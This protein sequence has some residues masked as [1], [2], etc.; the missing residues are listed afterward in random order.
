MRVNVY[1]DGFNFYYG[2][3][4]RHRDCKWLNLRA[5]F[6]SILPREDIAQIRYFTALIEQRDDDPQKRQRQLTLIRA[7]QT[8]PGIS[9]HYGTFLTN[10]K[11]LPLVTPCPIA[12]KARLCPNGPRSAEVQRTEEKGSDVNLATYLLVDGFQNAY[13][14]AVVVSNDSDLTEPIKLVHSVLKKKVGILNPHASP[15]MQLRQASSWFHL[16]IHRKALLASQFPVEF[17]DKN[18]TVRKPTGW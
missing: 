7:L 5:L 1:V 3:M 12:D 18:G 13:D 15:S 6:E 14:A 11:R 17:R 2:C 4:K 10:S 16:P 9:V 8:V